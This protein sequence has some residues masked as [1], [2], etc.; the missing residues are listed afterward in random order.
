MSPQG[1]IEH[2]NTGEPSL[3]QMKAA[4]RPRRMLPLA[5]LVVGLLGLLPTMGLNQFGTVGVPET[6]ART[7][8]Q[9]PFTDVNPYGANTF[10]SKEVEDWKREKTVQMMSE[11][12]LGWIKQQFPWS[13]IEP[14]PGRFWDD[15]YNQDSWA[16]YDRIV[17]LAEKYK[18]RIIARLD[19]TPEWAGG[20]PNSGV[21]YPPTDPNTFANFVSTFV[22]HYRGRIQFIQ[23]WNEPNLKGEWGN[24]VDAAAYAD[25]LKRAYASAKAADPNIVVLSAPLAQTLEQGDRGLD[26]LTYLQ[27]LYDAGIAGSYD[28]L[29]ANG[30]GFSQPPDAL[31]SPQILNFRRVEL[32]R[33]VMDRN[34]ESGKPIWLN[35]YGWNAAPADFPPSKL[36]WGRVTEEQQARY[37]VEGIRYAREHWPWMGVMNVWFFRQVGDIPPDDAQYYFRMVDTEFTPRPVYREVQRATIAQRLAL[38]G[39]Y[40]ALDPALDA[41]GQWTVLRDQPG[42]VALRSDHPNDQL[43]VRFRGNQLDLNAERGPQ[44]GRL[45]VQIDGTTNGLGQLARDPQGR[46]YLDLRASQ[47]SSS[48]IPVARGLDPLGQQREHTAVFTVLPG[49]AGQSAGTI[50]ISGVR[51]GYE[52]S[53]RPLIAVAVV[54]TLLLLFVLFLLGRVTRRVRRGRAHG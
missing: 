30:Y 33:Q 20:R 53:T 15:K 39:Y 36:Y 35:E 13:E 11:A 52:R 12:G 16:K 29:F 51:V 38:P 19:N 43:T 18:L 17:A 8:P 23:I 50:T 7:A 47:A 46:P 27:Q 26:E 6:T 25:L 21:N 45:G 22:T 5:L 14:K 40:G 37:T 54:A 3:V 42:A 28:I 2:S 31:P 34:G 49:P 10:L 44:G 41:K 9:L 1:V 24:Q 4:S 48:T 32:V